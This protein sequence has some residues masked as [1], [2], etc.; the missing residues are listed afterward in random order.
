MEIVVVVVMVNCRQIEEDLLIT[1]VVKDRMEVNRSHKDTTM[2]QEV[3]R[4]NKDRERTMHEDREGTMHEGREGTMHKDREGTVVHKNREGTVH[5]D[6]DRE[7]T[8]HKDRDRED[9]MHKD[10]HRG[11]T[12]HKDRH[13]GDIIHNKVRQR[14]SEEVRF[15]DQ[16][17]LS[18]RDII[19]KDRLPPVV[20][21]VNNRD[22]MPVNC[23]NSHRCTT[24]HDQ[25]RRSGMLSTRG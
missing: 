20:E 9:T 5:K 8:V 17:T 21:V 10:R 2:I 7:D 12:M 25:D 3:C 16:D 22:L 6:R 14:I 19:L 11:D 13:R 4:D 1:A 24:V 15:L 18:N 23:N